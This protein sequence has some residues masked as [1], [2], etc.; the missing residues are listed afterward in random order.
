[1][2]LDVK[3]K[4]PTENAAAILAWL[5]SLPYG[6]AE[7]RGQEE[8]VAATAAVPTKPAELAERE[9]RLQALFGAWQSEQTGEELNQLF[10][11]ARHTEQRDIEL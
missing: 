2:E 5:R 1:M 10:Q 6:V 3:L 4:F 7:L 8:A 11:Q 9:Q